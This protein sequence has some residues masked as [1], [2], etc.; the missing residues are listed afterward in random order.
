[1]PLL[2]ELYG[3]GAAIIPFIADARS[4]GQNVEGLTRIWLSGHALAARGHPL[5]KGTSEKAFVHLPASRHCIQ[6][7]LR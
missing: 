1:M 6:L 7:M 3:A 2:T 4:L 5:S